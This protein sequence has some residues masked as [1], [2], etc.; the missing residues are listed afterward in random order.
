MITIREDLDLF[1]PA[2]PRYVMLSKINI[3]QSFSEIK[4]AYLSRPHHANSWSIFLS[5]AGRWTLYCKFHNGDQRMIGY[6]TPERMR[7][8]RKSF[9]LRKASCLVT[10]CNLQCAY[11]YSAIE[12]LR[13]VQKQLSRTRSRY[14]TL[15]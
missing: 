3:D 5:W 15:C 10:C 14:I 11:S 8:L 2:S 4:L 7:L 12:M 6:D 9:V 13:C 1:T